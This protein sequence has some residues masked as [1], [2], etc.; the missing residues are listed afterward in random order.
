MKLRLAAIVTSALV[1]TSLSAAI[2][3]SGAAPGTPHLTG[4]S[5]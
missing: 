3:P 4:P 5:T 1:V 2:S